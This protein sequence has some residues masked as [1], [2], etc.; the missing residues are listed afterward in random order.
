MQVDVTNKPKI[1]AFSCEGPVLHAHEEKMAAKFLS[2]Y[3]TVKARILKFLSH[4]AS[5]L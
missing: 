2:T 1:I 5:G 3:K 4:K